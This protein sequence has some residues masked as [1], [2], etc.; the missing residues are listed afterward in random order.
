M[1]VS[2]PNDAVEEEGGGWIREVELPGVANCLA[3]EDE[4]KRD[5]MDDPWI[6]ILNGWLDGWC[7]PLL[8]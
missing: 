8:R 6:F 7:C 3:L 5:I 2:E 4:R 1:L